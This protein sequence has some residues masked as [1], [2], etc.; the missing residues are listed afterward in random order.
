[1]SRLASR[2]VCAGL[3][4]VAVGGASCGAPTSPAKSEATPAI[5]AAPESSTAAEPAA[6]APSKPSSEAE[7]AADEV[8]FEE[9]ERIEHWFAQKRAGNPELPPH[10]YQDGNPAER[11]VFIEFLQTEGLFEL[12]SH[13]PLRVIQHGPGHHHGV[14]T[15][16]VPT[17]APP[18]NCQ[19]QPDEQCEEFEW[20][21][22][23]FDADGQLV[24]LHIA[25]AG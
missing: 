7:R 3:L 21:E 9:R 6:L 22:L 20:V 2:P 10:L 15:I 17:G 12:K 18:P 1:M 13:T 11:D 24:A 14:R 5:S 23:T 4:F 16:S 25:A 8:G 19:K